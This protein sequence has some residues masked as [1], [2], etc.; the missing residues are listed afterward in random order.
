M[1]MMC[2]VKQLPIKVAMDKPK[3]AFHEGCCKYASTSYIQ[4]MWRGGESGWR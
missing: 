2:N 1:M 3:D 4:E